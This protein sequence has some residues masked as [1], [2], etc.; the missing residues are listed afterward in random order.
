M[1]QLIFK[2]CIACGLLIN[3]TGSSQTILDDEMLLEPGESLPMSSWRSEFTDSEDDPDYMPEKTYESGNG[4]Y[5]LFLSGSS[6]TPYTSSTVSKYGGA[7]CVYSPNSSSNSKQYHIQLQIPSGHEI[8]GFRYYYYDNSTDKTFASLYTIDFDGSYSDKQV[9]Y[10]S[11]NSGYG[12]IYKSLPEK[13]FAYNFRY[14]LGVRFVTY[15]GTSNQRFCGVRL[16]IDS[17]PQP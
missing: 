13:L 4:L 6:A 11:G 2:L 5:Y 16:W 14:K 9:V 8:K 7:G 10:S 15:D 12:S 3:G 17:T 1:K